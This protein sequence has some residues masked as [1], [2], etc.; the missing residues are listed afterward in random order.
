M[1]STD[2]QVRLIMR[3]RSQGRSQEQAAV[4]ANLK[5]RKTAAKY[6]REGKLPSELKQARQHRT[7]L[8]PFAAEWP[9]LAQMLETN[10]ELEAK[11]LFDWLCEQHPGQ[12]PEGQLR[13]LQRRVAE[14]RALNQA[15]VAILA[16][17]HRPG[18]VLQTDGVWLTELGVTLQ[19][20]LYKHLLIHCV[21]PYSNWEWGRLARTESLLAVR[22]GL[23]STLFKLGFVP[24]YHQTDNSSAVT[25]QLGATQ[26]AQAGVERSYNPAYLEVLSHFGLKPRTI[27]VN[28]PNENGDIEAA[29]GGLKQ[30]LAQHLMLRGSRDFA[31]L[32]DYERFVEQVMTR[33]NQRRQAR[34][35][36]ELA[37]MKPLTAAPLG[38]YQEYRLPVS[39]GSL[40]RVQKNVYSVPTSL[41]GQQVT[42]RVY[43]GQVEVYYRQRLVETMPRL[44]GQNRQQVNY[45]HLI[46]T[47]L[48]K[49]GGFRDYRYRESLFPTLVF[50]QAWETLNR[51]HSPRQADLIYLRLLRLAARHLESDVAAAL[52]LLLANQA[53]WDDTDVERL[54]PSPPVPVPLLAQPVVNLAQYDALLQ[55]ASYEPA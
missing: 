11:S 51:W 37:V 2:A 48:R 33:R 5:S 34:L 7:R 30:A 29:N 1:T 22:L 14:W 42:V 36:E 10:P 27:H 43:E 39:R 32:A 24:E 8:D 38:L 17:V 12:Y 31:S 41:M 3:E 54:M 44:I 53:R 20:E 16:Q 45:R 47:L 13:T 6:E 28:C 15:Q 25:C 19:G 49:P 21:L 55:E 50:R 40:I 23:Q 35:Q 18:E 4:K 52:S 9:E 46:D 26:A